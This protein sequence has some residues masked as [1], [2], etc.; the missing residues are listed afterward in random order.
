MAGSFIWRLFLR[1]SE[2]LVEVPPTS[3]CNID[4]QGR[5]SVCELFI[6]EVMGRETGRLITKLH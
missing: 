6:G 5:F 2:R 3:G 4:I 1:V